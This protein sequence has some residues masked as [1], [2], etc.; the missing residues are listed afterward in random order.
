MLTFTVPAEPVGVG[1][2]VGVAV[3][4]GVGVA[5]GVGV[6]VDPPAGTC[7]LSRATSVP[8]D[9]MRAC[10]N[11]DA[12]ARH[13]HGAATAWPRYTTGAAAYHFTFSVPVGAFAIDMLP[14]E[15]TIDG[16]GAARASTCAALVTETPRARSKT[17]TA[18]RTCTGPPRP[19]RCRGVRDEA[20]MR[21]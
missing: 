9:T 16:E 18:T 2:G 21:E 19:I 1:V 14:F 15:N 6:G 17:A 8:A 12:G 20:G 4:V 10:T 11:P 3:T 7:A 13:D 5:V